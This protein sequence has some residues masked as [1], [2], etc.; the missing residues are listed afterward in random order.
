MTTPDAWLL[1]LAGA[2][3]VGGGNI[4][5]TNAAQMLQASAQIPSALTLQAP[6]PLLRA[7]ERTIH[8]RLL[9]SCF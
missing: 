2:M 3:L 1:V 5:A 8:V 4:F 6:R 7:I 9:L